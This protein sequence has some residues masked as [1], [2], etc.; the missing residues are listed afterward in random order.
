MKAFNPSYPALATG[1]GQ[2]NT[3]NLAQVFVRSILVR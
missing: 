3:H 1:L 2:I